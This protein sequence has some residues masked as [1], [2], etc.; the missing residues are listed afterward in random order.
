MRNWKKNG[1]ESWGGWGV[2]LLY[3]GRGTRKLFFVCS[4]SAYSV[5]VSERDE[6]VCGLFPQEVLI[7]ASLFCPSMN[8]TDPEADGSF[9]PRLCRGRPGPCSRP[10]GRYRAPQRRVGR[11]RGEPRGTGG[12]TGQGLLIRGTLQVSRWALRAS[13]LVR[14]YSLVMN[15]RDCLSLHRAS[16][17]F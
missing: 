15:G 6:R 13:T 7:L 5:D 16:V 11:V 10:D 3:G 17:C 1:Q 12:P 9:R 2:S 14:W 4:C 8:S